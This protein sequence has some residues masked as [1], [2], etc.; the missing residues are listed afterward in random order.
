MFDQSWM[1]AWPGRDGPGGPRGPRGPRYRRRLARLTVRAALLGLVAGLTA[2]AAPPLHAD[3]EGARL[4][5]LLRQAAPTIATVRIVAK[6][7]IQMGGRSMDR[8][9]RMEFP[10]AVVDASG[11]VMTSIEPFAPERLMALMGGGRGRDGGP[12]IKT[13]PTDI[14]VV[15]EQED[16]EQSAFLAATDSDLG[17]AFLQV[18]GLAGRKLKA[19]D[20]SHPVNAVVGDLVVTVSRLG[21]Q[22]DAMP[23]FGTA[24]LSGDIVKPRRGWVLDGGPDAVGLPVFATSGG[25][26]G[27]MS[28]LAPGGGGDDAESLGSAISMMA[29]GMAGGGPIIQR[30]I[31]PAPAIAAVIDQARQQAAQK[32]AE[33][34]AKPA[35]APPPP[36]R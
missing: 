1:T 8:E 16:Q 25:V 17:L 32:A 31:V 35:P 13:V 30:Y 10:G 27:V 36:G 26:V 18:E 4:A 21:K 2:L 9:S 20:F 12:Q 3:E 22:N 23:Y 7:T 28:V 33:R 5:A 11:L 6:T 29:E 24:R 15:F 14:K 19:L 34:A